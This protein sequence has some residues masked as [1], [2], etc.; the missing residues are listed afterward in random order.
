MEDIERQRAFEAAKTDLDRTYSR[1]VLTLYEKTRR[2]EDDTAQ[3]L[4]LADQRNKDLECSLEALQKQFN[5]L[6]EENLTLRDEIQQVT[7]KMLSP[8]LLNEAEEKLV[9]YKDRRCFALFC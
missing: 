8:E 1:K 7:K 6:E 4:R 5:R 3:Q 2:C 9:C